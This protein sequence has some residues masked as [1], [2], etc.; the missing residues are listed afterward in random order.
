MHYKP[1]YR[2]YNNTAFN[3]VK[4]LAKEL[5]LPLNT[6]NEII[7]ASFLAIAKNANGRAFKWWT[8]GVNK[9][10][11]SWSLYPNVSSDSV[12]KVY[13]LLIQNG[14]IVYLKGFTNEQVKSMGFEILPLVYAQRLSEDLLK[15]AVFVE[16]NISPVLVNK[17]ETCDEKLKRKK[18]FPVAPKLGIKQINQEFGR[19]YILAY[20]PVIEMNKFWSQHPLYNPIQNEFYSS[21]G[22]VFHDE[23]FKAGGRWYGGWTFKKSNERFSFTI[24]KQPIVQVEINANFLS[25]ISGLVG[26]PM[27]IGDTWKDAYTPVVEQ[28]PNI[29]RARKKLKQV[30]MELAE[31]GDAYKLGSGTDVMDEHEFIVIRNLCLEAYPALKTMELNDKGNWNFTNEISFHEST[32][33]TNTLL[34]LKS[35]GVVAYGVHDCLIVKLGDEVLAADIFRSEFK[36]Y[37]SLFQK[38]HNK[39]ELNLDVALTLEFNA[40]NKVRIRGGKN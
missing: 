23:S 12:R 17:F 13:Q 32:I 19:A 10:L 31:T 3:L 40:S 34:K 11:K 25:L 33:L 22:R 6:Q 18:E 38:R 26:I 21:A 24:D 1:S 5:G 27:N 37:V 16:A 36:S 15:A 4:S 39:P 7:L 28:I 2:P 14:Y 20:R 30:I 35:L 29:A 8:G 9:K